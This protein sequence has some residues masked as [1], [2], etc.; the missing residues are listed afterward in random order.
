MPPSPPPAFLALIPARF[1]SS[2][3]PG[4]PLA[5]I[6]GR[7]MVVRVAERAL[8]A[9]ATQVAVATGGERVRAALAAPGIPVCRTR[10]DHAT[11]TG[12]LAEAAT[13]YGRA[14]AFDD[15]RQRVVAFG[16]GQRQ[17]VFPND[18]R[19]WDGAAWSVVASDHAPPGRYGAE[20]TPN[21]ADQR[22]LTSCG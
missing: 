6:A 2:P 13:A 20:V 4:T 3:L 22:T 14:L 21:A 17:G 5:D 12:R 15:T 10:A 1:A 16:G 19:E 9:G 11:G 8:E 7:P 18:T